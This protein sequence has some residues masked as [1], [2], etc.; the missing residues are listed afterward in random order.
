MRR[1]RYHSSGTELNDL[2]RRCETENQQTFT[3]TLRQ[4]ERKA[5]GGYFILDTKGARLIFQE[6]RRI[7]ERN[8]SPVVLYN[9]LRLAKYAVDDF[10]TT[11]DHYREPWEWYLKTIFNPDGRIRMAGI[12]LLD[13]YYLL[14]LD[15]HTAFLSGRKNWKKENR[16]NYLETV[17]R[18]LI[19]CFFH[20]QDLEKKYM[21]DHEDQL[22]DEDFPDV[23][24]RMPWA[25]DTHDKFLKSIRMGIEV[26]FTRGPWEE[27][28][29]Y[30]GYQEK[31]SKEFPE[32][33]IFGRYEKMSTSDL[34]TN[35]SDIK[36]IIIRAKLAHEK[37][38]YRDIEMSENTTL[39][40]VAK[41]ILDSFDFDFD[42][43]FGFGNKPDFYHSDIRYE[44][45]TDEDEGGEGGDVE[46]TALRDVPFFQKPG[47]KM[48]FLF[49]FGDDWEFEIELRSF[50]VIEKGKRYPAVLEEAGKAPEQ[51]PDYDE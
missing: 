36:S 8:H 9:A 26:F 12:Q 25:S 46:K 27:L 1:T 16:E 41:G 49:D 7:Y 39:Y 35:S 5:G 10:R 19:H 14:G 34:F 6:C 31:V 51:Y 43:L 13:R 40:K 38:I 2:L 11:S 50:G 28:M 33:S 47:D 37:R 4:M 44:L 18:F 29:Q 48:Y 20:L 3:Q 24:G 42:H 21:E 30:F 17:G 32:L 22:R 15:I 45:K 23:A